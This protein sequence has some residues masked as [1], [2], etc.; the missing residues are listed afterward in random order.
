MR[1]VLSDVSSYGCHIRGVT[2]VVSHFMWYG[3]GA[4]VEVSS[5]GSFYGC[6]NKSVMFEVSFNVTLEVSD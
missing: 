2:F 5:S 4:L 1:G 6:R 3:R